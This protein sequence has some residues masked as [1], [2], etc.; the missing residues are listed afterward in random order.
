MVQTF[1]PLCVD[2]CKTYNSCMNVKMWTNECCPLH[3][4]RSICNGAAARVRYICAAGA[5][6]AEGPDCIPAADGQLEAVGCSGMLQTLVRT[7]LISGH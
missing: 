4:G 2:S 3:A 5:H 6:M 1:R 7:A